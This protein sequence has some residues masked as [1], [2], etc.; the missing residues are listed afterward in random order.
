VVGKSTVSP[1]PRRHGIEFA[2]EY[3]HA[4][5]Y[6]DGKSSYAVGAWG[7]GVVLPL[8]SC[9]LLKMMMHFDSGNEIA[10]FV[11]ILI[12][13]VALR[14]EPS[15]C[16]LCVERREEDA[17]V[18]RVIPYI[19]SLHFPRKT[20]FSSPTLAQGRYLVS[21]IFPSFPHSRAL[22]TPRLV[23]TYPPSSPSIPRH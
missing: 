22:V 21:L 3:Y 19:Y 6:V 5:H 8:M 20:N 1:L 15:A 11:Q 16:T 7:I 10:A 13:I 14:R 12:R 23:T 17:T 4:I 2:W 18:M 9:S